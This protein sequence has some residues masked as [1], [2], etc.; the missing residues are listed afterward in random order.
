MAFV[1]LT[2]GE[3][4]LAAARRFRIRSR[5]YAFR[6]NVPFG[7]RRFFGPASDGGHVNEL[8]TLAARDTWP[9]AK[10]DL[11]L[12][13]A[14]TGTLEQGSRLQWLFPHVLQTGAFIPLLD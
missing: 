9:S 2:Y 12:V 14:A 10:P 1:V 6:S 3:A 11:E 13:V 7:A 8:A 4:G 5:W